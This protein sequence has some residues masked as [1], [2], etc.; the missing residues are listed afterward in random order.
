[1]RLKSARVQNYRSVRDTGWFGIEQDKTI[2]VGP[3]EA[4]KSAVLTAIQQL[5]AP[6]N[7]KK[8]DELRDYPR[9]LYN[10][11]TKGK[12]TAKT[13]PVVTG[14]FALDAEDKALLPETFQGVSYELT[15]YLDNHASHDLVDAPTLP[16]FGSIRKELLRLQ[17]HVDARVSAPVPGA[18]PEPKPSAK[19][20]AST[21]GWTDNTLI[22]AQHGMT[23]RGWL[24]EATV[25][26]DPNN[27]EQEKRLDDLIRA[28]QV[29]ATREKVL[30]TLYKRVPIFVLFSNYFRV[31]LLIHLAH[32]AQRLA[33]GVLDDDAYDYG[34]S[35]LLKLLGFTAQQLSDLGR[36]SEPNPKQTELVE[37]N[38]DQLDK[39][40]YQLNA[41]S[42]RLTQEIRAVWNPDSGRAEAD[43][44]RVTADGQYLKVSVEDELGVEIELN[45]RSE[46]FQWL[47]SF[48]VVFFA[49]ASDKHENAILLLD[50]PGVS[51]HALKQ[52]EFRSTIS[53]LAQN[54]QTIY[55]THSP[56]LVGP[57]ELDLVRV[58]ELIDR[59][60]G[61]KVH[62]TITSSDGAA[63]LPLQE[64]LGYDLAQSLFAQERNLVLEGLTDQWYI[65][66]VSG[67]LTA[68]GKTKLNEKIALI[69]A[70]AAS[71]V[72]YFAT[73]LH[74]HK[75]KVAAL[76]DSDT[77]G[78]Q[79]ASQDVLVHQLGHKGII[80]TKDHV[81]S[82][83]K[84]EIEDLLRDTLPII[85]RDKLGWDVVDLV[86][87]RPSQ[88]LLD[89]FE[90][91]VEDFS[92]YK[93]AKAFVRWSRDNDASALSSNERKRW[94]SLI[95]A[96][97]SALR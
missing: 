27:S 89:L 30:D 11:I 21:A 67:L 69:T 20:T 60:V 87:K 61:T 48:F 18:A 23:L 64:A 97:K 38:R 75:L 9:A 44:L 73:I 12:V 92:K 78:D 63:L 56:F 83:A 45:Q 22:D 39:R 42:V 93:L 2:L 19:L 91:E 55:T 41:A 53:R 58:V 84:A 46:G 54:N 49:E 66:A 15:R 65:E 85:A 74:A 57:G 25:L 81:N 24:D 8:F 68:E 90:R 59:T 3:N 13:T 80:R 77:A 95:S 34:N 36:V 51:L 32:L 86:G 43:K 5:K 52:R 62:T 17:A 71:K 33:S 40:G 26:V 14:V 6:A 4:G 35:C 96:I 50:E 70:N 47:V 88:P 94:N 31:R 16:T 1:M 37:A 28:T 29:A 7:V 79:A 72:V 10:D 82:I 76:L